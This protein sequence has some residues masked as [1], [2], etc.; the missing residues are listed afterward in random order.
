[1]ITAHKSNTEA[2]HGRLPAQRGSPDNQGLISCNLPGPR[3]GI[4]SGGEKIVEMNA[5]QHRRHGDQ[6]PMKILVV[7]DNAT[8]RKVLQVLLMQE[9]HAVL[10]AE[11]GLEAL[12]TL[13]RENIDAVI[14]DILMPRMDG[15]RLCYEIRQNPKINSIPFIAY[16][17][18]F[19]SP[20]DERVALDFGADRFLAKPALPEAIIKALHEAVE[21]RG[22]RTQPPR[23]PDELS[24]MKEYSETL[25]RKL[26]ETNAELS[27]ANQ[28]L[29]E[30][31]VLAEFIADIS[32]ALNHSETLPAILQ[33]CTEAMVRRLNAA[34][35]RIW[36]HNLKDHVLELQASA[37]MYTHI[38]GGHGRVPVGQFK[39]GLI[40]SERKPHL[41]NSVIGDPRVNDQEWAK[42]EGMI[43][44]AGY[45]LLVEDKLVGVMAMFSRK[46]LMAS[47]LQAMESVSKAI[48][49]SILR[50]RIDEEKQ[51]ET[52]RF[53]AILETALDCIVTMDHEGKILEF[54]PAAEKTFG[55][56]P[57]RGYR[58]G[59]RRIDYPPI[60][61]RAASRWT[62]TL[63][64]YRSRS[65]VRKTN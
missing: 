54:N 57:I 43:A 42:R 13:E 17:A 22:N 31:A 32:N 27:Q 6:L 30:R 5:L 35:A 7:D 15:Y 10:E 46:P 48:A 62:R 18:T 44:F 63:F 1:M 28:A 41:T 20:H 3:R 9:G 38:N 56:T 61:T 26:E 11:D 37:G 36:T 51:R 33:L 16:S 2:A 23:A 21:T 65:R 64:D 60:L 29:N 52:E 47:T 8:N 53:R 25:V 58:Q 34:F 55:Y 19:T 49:A 39:I 12:H 40:A 50:K 14:S 24:A 59:T 4:L 45:P